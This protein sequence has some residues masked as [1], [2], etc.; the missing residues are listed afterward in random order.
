MAAYDQFGSRGGL[1]QQY[2]EQQKL[3]VWNKARAV[4]GYDST[5]YRQDVAGAWIE[6]SKVSSTSNEL[7]LGWEIDHR[8]PTSK[9]GSDDLSNLEPLQW[10]NN[11][12]KGDD[13]PNWASMVS[14]DGNLN[15]YRRQN[16]TS[17]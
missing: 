5:K 15:V 11:R 2:D 3:A 17:R 13:Y 10:K 1:T 12:S 4:H 7:G 8:K 16:W 14:S 6:W 9:G